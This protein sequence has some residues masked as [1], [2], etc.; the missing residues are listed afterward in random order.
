[1]S[2]TR[3]AR[4]GRVDLAFLVAVAFALRM[5]VWWRLPNI[6]WADEVFQITE[7]AHR[8]VFGTGFVAWEWLAGIRSWLLPGLFAGLMEISHVLGL[9]DPALINLPGA[10]TMAALGCLPVVCGHGWGRNLYGRAGGAIAGTAAAVWSDMVYMSPHSLSEVIAGDLLILGLYLGCPAAA[11]PPGRR[12]LFGSGLVLGV[13]F[14]CRFHL[15][16][17]LLVAAIGICGTRGRSWAPLAAG[18]A[19]PVAGLGLLD[20]ITLGLPFQSIWLNYWYNVGKGISHDYGVYPW[21][22]L[23]GLLAVIWAPMLPGIAI[24][25]YF[26]ARRFPLPLLVAVAVLVTHSVF[27]HKEYRFVYPAIPLLIVLGGIGTADLLARAG[28]RLPLLA[29]PGVAAVVGIALWSAMSAQ[30]ATRP[31]MYPLWTHTAG[32]FAAFRDVDG[33][34]QACGVGTN[35]AVASPGN[36]WLRPDIPLYQLS[37]RHMTPAG[38]ARYAPAFNVMT[39]NVAMRPPDPRYRRLACHDGNYD[40]SGTPIMRVCVWLRPGG[41]DPSAAPPHE[42]Y[43]PDYFRHRLGLAPFDWDAAGTP[44]GP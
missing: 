15:S 18:A 11:A 7:P 31:F 9:R 25:L 36:T 1:M 10:V 33:I 40:A 35:H 5:A 14:A 29:R 13:T 41:C 34:P 43:W 12:R 27:A 16:P 24:T 39:L 28:R 4:G 8:L 17:A 44:E 38:F 22:Y 42:A 6:D 20:W 19:I 37:L 26:G 21:W 2:S 23:L 3:I 30:I 32:F